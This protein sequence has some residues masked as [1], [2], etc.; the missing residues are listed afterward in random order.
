MIPDYNEC[1]IFLGMKLSI[2][3]K[4]LICDG[5]EIIPDK[6]IFCISSAL[7]RRWRDSRCS[8]SS[9]ASKLRRRPRFGIQGISKNI[10]SF[11]REQLSLCSIKFKR[12]SVWGVPVMAPWKR[13]WLV[14]MRTQV[15]SLAWLSGW[16]IRRCRELGC[17]SQTQ[18]GSRVDV[19]VV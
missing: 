15:Q 13:T 14:S 6:H 9:K 5:A 17:R 7:V 18:V 19:A 8:F 1:V 4:K 12:K 2:A 16:R 3:L 11:V 10:L